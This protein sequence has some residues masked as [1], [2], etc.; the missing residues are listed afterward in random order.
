MNLHLTIFAQAAFLEKLRSRKELYNAVGLIEK[1]SILKERQR[2]QPGVSTPSGG[3]L[4]VPRHPVM[5]R[6]VLIH[7]NAGI[8]DVLV[9]PGVTVVGKRPRR[10]T[11]RRPGGP[12]T[13]GRES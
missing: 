3:D 8:A 7:L 4:T 10:K 13:P 6:C 5:S 11:G 2:T 9:T 12:Q 1:F